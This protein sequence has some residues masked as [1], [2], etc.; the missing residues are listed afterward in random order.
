M[1][2]GIFSCMIVFHG[3]ISTAEGEKMMLKTGVSGV[4]VEFAATRD[5]VP[6]RS[7]F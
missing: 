3:N 7:T 1:F 4:G 2:E 5:S 6:C